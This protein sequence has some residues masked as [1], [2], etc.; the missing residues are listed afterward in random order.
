MRIAWLCPVMAAMSLAILADAADPV[1]YMDF[2][3]WPDSGT[4]LGTHTHQLWLV[5]TGQVREASASHGKAAFLPGGPGATNFVRS[6][7][8]SNGYGTI[9]FRHANGYIPSP[10][11]IQASSDSIHWT[12]LDTGMAGYT[13]EHYSRSFYNPSGAFIRICNMVTSLENYAFLLIDEGFPGGTSPPTGWSFSGI[14]GMYFS[15]GNYGREPPSLKFDNPGDHITTPVLNQPTN[16]SYWIK[17][18]MVSSNSFFLVEATSNDLD[19]TIIASNRP[20]ANQPRTNINAIATNTIRVR[21]TYYKSQGNVAFDD[22]VILGPPNPTGGVQELRLD[23]INVEEAEPQRAQDFDNWPATSTYGFYTYKGW[24]VFNALIGATYA[25]SGQAVRFRNDADAKYLL[26]PF[27]PDGLGLVTFQYRHWDGAD[28]AVVYRLQTS[29]DGVTWTDQDTITITS[30]SYSE[31]RRFFH[32]DEGVYVRLFWIS[33]E[34]RV[35]F[36]EIVLHSAQ[37]T[38]PEAPLNV[39]AG[40]GDHIDY[41]SIRWDDV[42]LEAAYLIWR[43]VS[44]NVSTATVLGSGVPDVPAYNDLWAVPGQ[45][46][47]YWITAIN[48]YGTSEWSNTDSGYRRL[49]APAAL[50]ASQG[51]HPDKVA[52]TWANVDGETGFGMWRHPD[53]DTHAA[54]CIGGVSVNTL[55]FDDVSAVPGQGYY[56]WVRASNLTSYSMSDFGVPAVGFRAQDP[57]A[58][59]AE[60]IGMTVTTNIMI[61][62]SGN[63]GATPWLVQ[64]YF[65]TNPVPPSWQLILPFDQTL[66][67]GTNALMFDRPS[68]MNKPVFYRVLFTKP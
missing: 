62:A 15:S 36:D 39:S 27:L 52:L 8:F 28:P 26:S 24:I 65:T 50:T 59:D 38:V 14:A 49:R 60:I 21:F 23:D 3:D 57:E 6:P 13:D 16:L 37:E 43:S 12:T 7:F 32:I 35:L 18:Q 48:A 55:T 58:P 34:Q 9:S 56:Y 30:A 4:N 1:R 54:T 46:Y 63:T 11:A 67:D 41:V 64:P 19:W 61:F 20:I 51:T 25:Y 45:L 22:V 33:G 44:N 53:N 40:D 31:Y 10:F 66:N 17:G 5:Q 68:P 47:Y 29:P 2:N 42:S